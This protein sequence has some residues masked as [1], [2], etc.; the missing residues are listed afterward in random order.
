MNGGISPDH[1][2]P[3]CFNRESRKKMR[4]KKKKKERDKLF[5][6]ICFE[7]APN[8]QDTKREKEREI[9]PLDKL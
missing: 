6:S 5:S 7:P 9:F 3:L 8:K 4:K 1:E 2:E